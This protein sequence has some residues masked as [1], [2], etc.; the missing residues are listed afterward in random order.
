MPTYT[1][2]YSNIKLTPKQKKLI[3]EF[4]ESLSESNTP[5]VKKFKNFLNNY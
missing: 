1:V 3:A 4:N 2:K 5:R